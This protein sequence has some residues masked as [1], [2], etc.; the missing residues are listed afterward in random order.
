M[1]WKDLLTAEV[2]KVAIDEWTGGSCDPT[3]G[4]RV[5]PE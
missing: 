4:R 1:V 2:L 5:Q 3:V